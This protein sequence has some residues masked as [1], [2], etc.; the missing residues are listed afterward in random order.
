M[1]ESGLVPVAVTNTRGTVFPGCR[2]TT[3][4]GTIHRLAAEVSLAGVSVLALAKS[5]STC[6]A[7]DLLAELI[8][9]S[10]R[11]LISTLISIMTAL[12]PPRY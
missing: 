10:G 2:C 1:P 12:Q 9:V 6:E 11:L 8:E 3:R 4:H 5:G 7:P